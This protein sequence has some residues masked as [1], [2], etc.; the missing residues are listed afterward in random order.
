MAI[1]ATLVHTKSTVPN[2]FFARILNDGQINPEIQ[3]GSAAHV[4]PTDCRQTEQA[5][6]SISPSELFAVVQGSCAFSS[7]KA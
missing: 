4:V 7:N 3:R 1:Q 5:S 6:A 2:C